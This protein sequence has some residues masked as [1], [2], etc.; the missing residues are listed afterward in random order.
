MQLT[1]KGVKSYKKVIGF[2]LFFIRKLLESSPK[3]W[4][5]KEIKNI[6]TMNFDFKENDQG[7]D[8]TTQ[9]TLAM[10]KTKIS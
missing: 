7:P 1:K 9:L 8:L 4:V 5:F 6:N 10:F 3:E 2:A